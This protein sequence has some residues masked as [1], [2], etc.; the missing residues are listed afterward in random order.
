MGLAF[1]A[2]RQ[3]DFP[4]LV[5]MVLGLYTKD[6]SKST[7]MSVEK[8]ALS[9]ERLILPS[10]NG[11]IIIFEE[12]GKQ[13]GYAIVNRFWSNEYSGWIGF[14]DELFIQ[15]SHRNQGVG[16]QFFKELEQKSTHDFVAFMLE[17][18]ESNPKATRFYQRIGFEPHHNMVL[19][20]L[21]QNQ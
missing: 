11:E 17:T 7:Q 20:K 3:S 10:N 12:S 8:I 1:R 13:I 9:V 6:G 4:N 5:E 21:M 15:P 16:E 2:Y 19:F 14:I 18:L